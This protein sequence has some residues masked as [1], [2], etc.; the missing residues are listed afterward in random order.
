[1]AISKDKFSETEGTIKITNGD[2]QALHKIAEQYGMTDESDVIAF[3]IGVLNEANGR[4][5]QVQKNDGSL[6]K[7][8]PSDDLVSKK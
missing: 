4:P 8:A 1:M 3:A 2:F 6:I 5:I 7:F